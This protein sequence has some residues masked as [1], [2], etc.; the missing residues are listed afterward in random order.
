MTVVHLAVFRV[1]IPR[2][3]VWQY[4]RFKGIYY[5]HLQGCDNLLQPERW[6][7]YIS[8]KHWYSPTISHDVTTHQTTIQIFKKDSVRVT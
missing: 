6:T 8:P 5:L 1:T 7:Q 2:S 4:H 3:V